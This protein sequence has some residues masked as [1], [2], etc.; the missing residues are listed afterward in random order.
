MDFGWLAVVGVLLLLAGLLALG[1]D[2]LRQRRRKKPYHFP[3]IETTRLE[4]PTRSP[5]SKVQSMPLSEAKGPK[6]GLRRLWTVYGRG[7][8]RPYG[9]W[10]GA[11]RPGLWT[12]P[13]GPDRSTLYVLAA[14]CCSLL[15]VVA[16]VAALASRSEPEAPAGRGLVIALPYL[17]L[18]IFFALPFLIIFK[19]SLSD[20]ELA[21]PPYVPVFVIPLFAAFT[22]GDLIPAANKAR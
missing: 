1:F 20:T 8:P 4:I 22:V 18:L 11:K 21:Q 13:K 16:G 17:W 5:K 12:A 19:I 3:E 2:T 14:V 9:L 6:S 10:T 15:L 7:V